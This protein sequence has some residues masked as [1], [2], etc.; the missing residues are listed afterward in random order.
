LDVTLCSMQR[1]KFQIQIDSHS[2]LI[3]VENCVIVM[4]DRR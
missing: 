1:K 2:A 4:L 3:P